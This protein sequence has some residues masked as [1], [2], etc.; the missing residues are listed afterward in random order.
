MNTEP[1]SELRAA[2]IEDDGSCNVDAL[3]ARLADRQ[4][5]AGRRVRGLIMVHP[6]EVRTC[7]TPMVLVDLDTAQQYLVSQPLGRDSTSCR[8]DPGGFAQA[9]EVLR[10][11]A[12]EAPDLVICNRFGGL[13]ADG[14]GFR[15][16]LIDILAADLP[17]LTVVATRH[18]PA[19]QSFTG[20]ATVLP[21]L[22]GAAQAWVDRV[23]AAPGLS[24]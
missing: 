15:S 9:S 5:Q 3:L 2:A 17:L 23:L 14:G 19:W 4:R 8:A 18:I 7:A 1:T 16:E 20:G 12:T 13:E 10:R 11:A 6:G 21:A 22:E 24:P